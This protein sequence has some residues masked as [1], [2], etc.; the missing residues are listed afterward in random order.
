MKHKFDIWKT[1]PGKAIID[2]KME[3]TEEELNE[4]VLAKYLASLCL[5]KL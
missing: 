3:I 1:K 5:T 4:L 2:G